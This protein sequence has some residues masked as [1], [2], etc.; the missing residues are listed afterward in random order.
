M[1]RLLLGALFVVTCTTTRLGQFTFTNCTD[2]TRITGTDLGRFHFDR[3]EPPPR[4]EWQDDDEPKWNWGDEDDDD[5][6]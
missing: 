4:S 5:G 3:V 6:E 1:R 2:G